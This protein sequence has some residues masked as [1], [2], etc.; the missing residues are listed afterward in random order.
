M[1]IYP[2][3]KESRCRAQ[4]IIVCSL[5]L[6]MDWTPLV[7]R[8]GGRAGRHAVVRVV[9]VQS[10]PMARRPAMHLKPVLPVDCMHRRRPDVRKVTTSLTR[11]QWP[12]HGHRKEISSARFRC[13]A[14][15]R[16]LSRRYLHL[17]FWMWHSYAS[18]KKPLVPET[19]CFCVCPSVSKSVSLCIQKTLPST[20]VRFLSMPDRSANP[21]QRHRRPIISCD[22]RTC[23]EQSSYQHHSINLFAIFQETT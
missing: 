8:L 5:C 3:H 14:V 11:R 9:P 13:G 15:Q 1:V 12:A 20:T 21:A 2:N 6:Q 17:T 7:W 23:M 22:C 4:F 10:R 19:S 16:V 18:V